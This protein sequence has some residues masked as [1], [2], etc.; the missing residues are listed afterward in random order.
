MMVRMV[1][2][3]LGRTLR[4]LRRVRACAVISL[5]F[6]SAAATADMIAVPKGASGNSAAAQLTTALRTHAPDAKVVELTGS[7]SADAALIPRET[8]DR[9]VVYAIGPDAVV[10]SKGIDKRATVVAL[11]VPNPQRSATTATYVSVYPTLATVFN[12]L[13]TKLNVKSA[14]LVFSPAQ[15]H[16]EALRFATAAAQRGIHLQPIP[17]SAGSAAAP[18]RA[19]LPTL[20]VVIL[21]VDPILFDARTLRDIEAVTRSAHVPTV[22]FLPELPSLGITIALVPPVEA[23]AALA[24]RSAQSLAPG[25]S[26]TVEVAVMDVIV[27]KKSA[28][29]VGLDPKSIGPQKIQ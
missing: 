27:S 12:F 25:T 15:N 13:A 22:G 19:A 6:C 7:T 11:N 3:V 2:T 5:L 17:V 8:R 23:A 1:Q 20:N 26:R 24:A 18:L 16:E 4:N 28:D 10:A 29:E 14:G 9:D 21:L